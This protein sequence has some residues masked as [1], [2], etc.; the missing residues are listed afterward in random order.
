MPGARRLV[1]TLPLLLGCCGGPSTA[2]PSPSPVP[3][4]EQ[5]RPQ[6]DVGSTAPASADEPG[7]PQPHETSWILALLERHPDEFGAL[8]DDPAAARL[9]ILVTL[10][11]DAAADPPQLVHHGFREGA[12][13]IYPASSIKTFASVAALLRLQALQ[14]QGAAVGLDTPVALC[15]GAAKR[16]AVTPDPSNH[17]GGVVTLGHEVRKMQLV[18]D[19]V[20]FNRLYDFVGHRELNETVWTLGFPEVRIHHR[21]FDSDDPKVR[22]TTPRMEL[23]P[24]RGDSVI[25]EARTSDL[26]LTPPEL[27]GLEVGVAHLDKDRNRIDEPL[28]FADKNYASIRDLHRLIMALVMPGAPGVPDLGLSEEHRRFLL[29]AMTEDPHASKNPVYTKPSDS[30][31]RYK[32]MIRG[33]MRVMP[34]ARIRYVNKPGRAYGFHLDSAYVE[35]RATRRAMFVT[36]VVHANANGVVNDN[37]YGYDEVTRPFLQNLGE[38]LARE[39][40]LAEP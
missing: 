38:A 17:D 4:S 1:L 24:L 29:D 12:E 18:S 19:N 10:V 33:M 2:A 7:A 20:A 25:I 32:T 31:L 11:P 21:M 26:E 35:D 34:L 15:E 36:T 8:L 9:Q 23:R 22:R 37:R 40:L 13:F 39:W 27:P 16:C 5:S 28:S 30:G 14:E 6:A 3:A